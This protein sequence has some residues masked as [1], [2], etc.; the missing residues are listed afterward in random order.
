M[1]DPRPGH[2]ERKVELHIADV[3]QNIDGLPLEPGLSNPNL[4][5]T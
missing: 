1:G 4:L 5:S 3:L 2:S